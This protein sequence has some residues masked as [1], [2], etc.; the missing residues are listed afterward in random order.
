M[1]A[2][3]PINSDPVGLEASGFFLDVAVLILLAAP[4]VM[5]YILWRIFVP[6]KNSPRPN[7]LG[8]E[9]ENTSVPYQDFCWPGIPGW[10]VVL[11]A[12]LTLMT[13]IY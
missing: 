3:C 5:L 6:D 9:P 4:V 13:L 1:I 11:Y 12:V 8:L 2:L 10:K 7:V